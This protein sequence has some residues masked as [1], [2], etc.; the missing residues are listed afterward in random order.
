MTMADEVKVETIERTIPSWRYLALVEKVRRLNKRARRLGL[1]ETTIEFVGHR[2][3]RWQMGPDWFIPVSLTVLK[4][5]GPEMVGRTG[6]SIVAVLTHGGGLTMVCPKTEDE[7]LGD[8][9]WTKAEPWCEHCQSRRDRG[10]TFLVRHADEGLKQVGTTCLQ[11]YTGVD[12]RW[13]AVSWRMFDFEDED[14]GRCWGKGRAQLDTVAFVTCCASDIRQRGFV[15]KKNSRFP[16]NPSTAFE[17]EALYPH[18]WSDTDTSRKVVADEI[19]EEDAKLAQA[20]LDWAANLKPS[21]DF[22][23]SI[24]RIANEETFDSKFSGFAAAMIPAY[25]RHLEWEAERAR[26]REE[27]EAERKAAG[28]RNEHFGEIKKRYDLELKV[29]QVKHLQRDAWPHEAYVLVIFVDPEGRRF[30]WFSQS[31]AA[32]DLS[33]GS[34]Y[35]ARG[36][37]KAHDVYRGSKQT[38]LTRVAIGEE[39]AAA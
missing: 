28:E 11:E 8:T 6:W 39:V 13:V 20:A 27:K 23:G 32:F 10:T 21:N 3:E 35:Q 34:R 30:K 12:P 37:V 7:D 5:T 16:K 26:E 33:E 14:M 4:M 2:T 22:L 18:L 38:L 31:A 24:H 17:A 9:D 29:E 1:P 36:T 15:S 25:R 19:K